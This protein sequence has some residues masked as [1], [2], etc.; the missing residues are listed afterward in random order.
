MSCQSTHARNLHRFSVGL[1]HEQGRG[2][3]PNK[4]PSAT[5]QKQLNKLRPSGSST[6]FQLNVNHVTEITRLRTHKNT[7]VGFPLL[8]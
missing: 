4:A 1:R 2:C 7:L 5:A 6:E 8:I 3:C